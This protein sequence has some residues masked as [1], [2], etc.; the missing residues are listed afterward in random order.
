M[1]LPV[2]EVLRE[3]YEGFF[4]HGRAMMRL[5]RYAALAYVALIILQAAYSLGLEFYYHYYEIRTLALLGYGIILLPWL[6]FPLF[7]VP[8]SRYIILGERNA[9]WRGYYR[10]Y[11][12]AT[13]VVSL[14][15]ILLI[16]GT[17]FGLIVMDGADRT[18]GVLSVGIFLFFL[19]VTL[20]LQ[21]R[22]SLL[23]PLTAVRGGL[24]IKE[25]WAMT[26]GNCGRL[27][28]ATA[29]A[30]L[31]VSVVFYLVFSLVFVLMF[32]VLGS[33]EGEAGL[34]LPVLFILLFFVVSLASFLLVTLLFISV[35]SVS[36][37]HLS[38]R[39]AT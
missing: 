24:L 2:V 1:K 21:V 25:A 5:V 17:V 14:P 10:R 23:L 26:G 31:P 27:C 33:A 36:Y 8:W 34:L 3:T 6:I 39:P 37:R 35:L 11:L 28:L 20:Y 13:V 32:T 22:L 18:A 9:G 7:A 4:R 29:G 15:G 38:V 12:L 19:L 16:A 30:I